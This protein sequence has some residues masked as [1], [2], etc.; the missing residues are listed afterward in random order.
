MG[1]DDPPRKTTC[2]SNKRS[3]TEHARMHG[4]LSS[5]AE[6]GF[7]IRGRTA[8]ALAENECRGGKFTLHN[9]LHRRTSKLQMSWLL[10]PFDSSKRLI[11]CDG[12]SNISL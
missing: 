1:L 10:Y 5:L 2:Q 12:T 11:R 6:F 9:S 3:N 8:A 4:L 7:Q